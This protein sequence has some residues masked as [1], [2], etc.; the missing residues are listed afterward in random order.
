MRNGRSVGSGSWPWVRCQ[1]LILSLL[2]CSWG[3]STV[4]RSIDSRSIG[5]FESVVGVASL[6]T[7]GEAHGFALC[8]DR[9]GLHTFSRRVGGGF[10]SMRR[11]HTCWGYLCLVVRLRYWRRKGSASDSGR[12]TPLFHVKLRTTWGRG[13]VAWGLVLWTAIDAVLSRNATSNRYVAAL[14]ET[15]ECVYLWSYWFGFTRN[16]GVCLY[17]HLK[18]L[19]GWIYV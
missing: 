17:V 13:I 9:Y 19:N 15:L 18:Q 11:R 5:P 16:S 14:V 3:D 12:H 2:G 7:A 4:L 8:S 6:K 1:L 10:D